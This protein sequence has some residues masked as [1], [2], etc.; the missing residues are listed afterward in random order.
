MTPQELQLIENAAEEGAKRAL[1]KVGL[2]D[3]DAGVDIKELRNL[4]DAWRGAKRTIGQTIVRIITTALL[5][6]LAVGIYAK[7]GGDN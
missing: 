3:S 6:A 1:E 4:L 2:S 7:F 5:M